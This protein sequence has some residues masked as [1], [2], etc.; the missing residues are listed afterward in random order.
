MVVNI[1]N[2]NEILKNFAIGL[3]PLFAFILADE[4]YGTETGLSVGILSGV[5]YAVYYYL[6]FRQ[7]EKFILFDTMLILVLGGISILLKDEIFLS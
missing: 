1:P 3:V 7:I 4:L 5:V 6:R 2:K